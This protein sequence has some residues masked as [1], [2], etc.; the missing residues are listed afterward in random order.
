MTNLKTYEQYR[1]IFKYIEKP[2]AFVD[3]DYFDENSQAIQKRAANKKIRIATKSLRC[4]HLLR[5]ILSQ[6]PQ[7]QGLMTY[8]AAET[9][10]LSHWGFDDLLLGYPVFEASQIEELA[11][12][13]KKGKQIT[14]MADSIAHVRQIAQVAEKLSVQIPICLDIDMSSDFWGAIHF[15]VY[16]SS[17]QTPEQA[18]VVAEEIKHHSF[19]KLAGIM[20]YEAQIAGLGT[21]N[22]SLMNWFISYLKRKSIREL[23]QRRKKVVE[24]I[25]VQNPDLKF[26]NGGGT[27]SLESTILEPVVSEVTV[28]SG[29]YCAG[30]FDNYLEFN[31][32][33]AV[34]FAIEITRQPKP[35]IY[36]CAGGGYVASGAVGKEKLP[37]PYLPIGFQL[38]DNEGVGEVQTPIIYKGEPKLHLGDPIFLRHAKAGEIGERFTHFY[39]VE[40]N[41]I[42]G[43]IPSYRGEGQCFI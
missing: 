29:F 42:S 32:L 27:G 3:L 7:Y 28:G 39:T 36:T 1:E 4:T 31:H 2:F 19:V 43:K 6:S 14:L 26:V 40:G 24:T 11:K 25:L 41:K 38:I 13:I 9:V 34:A 15:G 12:E 22:P 23:A 30:L 5:R 8:C 17:L 37:K 33:P 20:G 35:H 16:R 10:Y 18:L 21:K